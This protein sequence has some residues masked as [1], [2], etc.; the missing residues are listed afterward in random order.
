M[1]QCPRPYMIMPAALLSPEIDHYHLYNSLNFNTYPYAKNQVLYDLHDPAAISITLNM[2]YKALDIN[3][4]IKTTFSVDQLSSTA[5]MF[6]KYNIR[7][8]YAM[9]LS[10]IIQKMQCNFV[11]ISHF[12]LY[13]ITDMIKFNTIDVILNLTKSGY[14]LYK[15]MTFEGKDFNHG[16]Q[17]LINNGI[18]ISESIV[19][20]AISL[21][22]SQSR[23]HCEGKPAPH[24]HHKYFYKKVLFSL[25]LGKVLPMVCFLAIATYIYIQ[26][27]QIPESVISSKSG[28]S[29]SE[30]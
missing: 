1:A 13:G 15:P 4:T 2:A 6:T 29:L 16:L 20:K 21:S 28:I 25:I 14:S 27:R 11:P 9:S 19:N 7:K 18:R 22:L 24:I 12:E 26:K 30:R 23:Y 5:G 10:H 17:Q 8:L 3:G